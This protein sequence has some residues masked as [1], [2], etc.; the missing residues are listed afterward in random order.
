MLSSVTSPLGSTAVVAERLDALF[1][2]GSFDEVGGGLAG[3]DFGGG[4]GPSEGERG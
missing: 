2:T 1:L 3:F 4:E